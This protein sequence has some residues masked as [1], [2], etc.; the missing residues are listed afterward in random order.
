MV[1]RTPY[2]V[3]QGMRMA[4]RHRLT[5]LLMGRL[6]GR[7]IA[8]RLINDYV[9]RKQRVDSIH[10]KPIISNYMYQILMRPG[11]TEFALFNFFLIGMRA[12]YGLAGPNL[13]AS[14]N[15]KVPFICIYGE[16]DWV[17]G[18]NGEAAEQLLEL[19]RN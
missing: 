19:K 16:D 2:Y 14:P 8:I 1:T 12:K 10:H 7:S 3:R 15:F 13:L 6:M 4:F 5:P 11:T 17:K 18:L 9:N